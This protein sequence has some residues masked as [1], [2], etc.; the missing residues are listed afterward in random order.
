MEFRTGGGTVE[1]LNAV[2]LWIDA[3]ETVAVVGESGS[4]KSVTALA[5]LGL[6]G[7]GRVSGGRITWDGNDITGADNHRMRAVRGKDISVIFQDP[8]TSLDPLF[9]IGH[10]L[11]EAYRIHH[12][13]SK[14]KARERAVELLDLVGIPEPATKFK[15]Y[16]HQLSGGQR[17]R[18]MIAGALACDPRLL[19]AD[20][21]TTALDV[22]VEAQ[23]LALIRDLQDRTGVGLMLITH[24]MGVVAEMADRVV[25][26]Y[27]GQV[28]ET[29][30][31]DEILDRPQHPYT[32]ALLDAI[33]RRDTPRDQEMPAIPGAVPA[34]NEMPSGCR[35]V[36]RCSEAAPE[37]EVFQPLRDI[38]GRQVRCWRPDEEPGVLAPMAEVAR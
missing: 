5:V 36:T 19:I 4:G 13:V 14:R 37:C 32:R 35:F 1:A 34:L 15:A 24:D 10:Q 31:A 18:V 23:V 33:P 22:T 17:Q 8:M 11:V 27:A 6:L 28:V 26:F 20:E 25:V 38:S 16:P 7:N 3:G 2:D 21:P 12:D 9:T 30:T 29:G